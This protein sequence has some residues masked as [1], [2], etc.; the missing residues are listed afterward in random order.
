MQAQPQRDVRGVAVLG[1]MSGA[2]SQAQR[3]Q[4]RRA[5][6]CADVHVRTRAGVV[7]SRW[8]SYCVLY[9]VDSAPKGLERQARQGQH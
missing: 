8:A 5:L 1:V 7:L 2:H 3:K 6:M 4:R 9:A